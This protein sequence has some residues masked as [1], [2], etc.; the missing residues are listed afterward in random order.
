MMPFYIPFISII[1]CYLL[2]SGKESKYYLL[3]KYIVFIVAFSVLVFAEIMVRYSG[4]S[5]LY[6]AAY[7]LL[8]P[9]LILLNYLYLTKIFKYENLGK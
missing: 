2:S 1:I 7:Y 8:P 5:I 9:S 3:K 4:Q 6:S